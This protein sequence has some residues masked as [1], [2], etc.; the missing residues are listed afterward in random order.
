VA[1]TTNLSSLLNPAGANLGPGQ[2]VLNN[3]WAPVAG[4]RY[5][6]IDL[7]DLLKRIEALEQA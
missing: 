6:K 4:G 7:A 5:R 2:M 3:V 1:L